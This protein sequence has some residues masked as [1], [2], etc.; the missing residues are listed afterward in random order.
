MVWEEVL[1]GKLPPYTGMLLTIVGEGCLTC[2][3]F[4]SAA[5]ERGDHG[6]E[7]HPSNQADSLCR[8]TPGISFI[9]KS[10]N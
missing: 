9:A 6:H 2:E 10:M 3:R 4:L 8:E 5:G 7:N 1:D